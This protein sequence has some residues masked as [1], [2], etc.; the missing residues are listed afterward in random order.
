[1]YAA[2]MR[3]C[4]VAGDHAAGRMGNMFTIAWCLRHAIWAINALASRVA[5]ATCVMLRQR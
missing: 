3:C 4:F 5:D 2:G 1:M